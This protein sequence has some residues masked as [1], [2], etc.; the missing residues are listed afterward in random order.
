MCWPYLCLNKI[1]FNL[2]AF[3]FYIHL[4]LLELRLCYMHEEQRLGGWSRLGDWSR[5]P[6]PFCGGSCTGNT[7]WSTP[8]RQWTHCLHFFKFQSWQEKPPS[9]LEFKDKNPSV[10]RKAIKSLGNR[11]GPQSSHII[12]EMVWFPFLLHEMPVRPWESHAGVYSV[13]QL[14]DRYKSL[15][16]HQ[17]ELCWQ[18]N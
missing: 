2:V 15:S 3:K 1:D 7:P 12:Q 13:L 14:N 18:T 9:V 8:R 16:L 4:S 5:L 17:Q 6:A 10:G 11:N